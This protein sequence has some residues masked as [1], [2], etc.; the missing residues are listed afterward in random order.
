MGHSLKNVVN[1]VYY[2]R[3]VMRQVGIRS[4]RMR[5]C[6][7]FATSWLHFSSSSVHMHNNET[8][9]TYIHIESYNKL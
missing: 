2:E 5:N 3:V 8:I 7:I 1:D 6:V 9:F 4:G